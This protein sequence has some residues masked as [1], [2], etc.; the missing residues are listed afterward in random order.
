MTASEPAQRDPSQLIYHMQSQPPGVAISTSLSHVCYRETQTIVKKYCKKCLSLGYRLSINA[1]Q[2]NPGTNEPE[3]GKR[4][5]LKKTPCVSL[6][7]HGCS[8]DC[9]PFYIHCWKV[10]TSFNSIETSL[11]LSHSM[12]AT[13]SSCTKNRPVDLDKAGDKY[14][15]KTHY[16]AEIII[17]DFVSGVQWLWLIPL[18]FVKNSSEEHISKV[19]ARQCSF[20]TTISHVSL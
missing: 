1:R 15:F 11:R 5:P 2:Q 10:F 18:R 8:W 9:T 20:F 17:L 4:Q 7:V 14:F 3:I 19:L 6:G 16:P 13:G 12:V